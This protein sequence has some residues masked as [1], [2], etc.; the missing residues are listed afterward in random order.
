MGLFFAKQYIAFYP[1]EIK[2]ASSRSKV[3]DSLKANESDV[4]ATDSKDPLDRI[5]ESPPDPTTL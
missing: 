2:P 5:N 3:E 1:V 4:N